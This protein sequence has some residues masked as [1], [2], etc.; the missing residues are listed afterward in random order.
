MK[1]MIVRTP[2]RS[3]ENCWLQIDHYIADNSLVIDIVN[4]DDNIARI[5]TCLDRLT[6]HEDEAFVDMNNCPWAED[7]IHR[8]RLGED[9]QIREQSGFCIYPLYKFDMDRIKE[10]CRE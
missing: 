1:K 6:V 4:P 8:Y 9:T 10:F 2:Y 5:T 3:Y 7:F